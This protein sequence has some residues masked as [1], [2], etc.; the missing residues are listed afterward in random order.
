MI[1]NKLTLG[2]QDD[3]S[4]FT[5]TMVEMTWVQVKEAAENGDIV[6][7]PIGVIEE[8]GPHL[9][10]SPDVYMAYVFCKY[11][12]RNLERKGIK[13]IIAPPYY[14]GISK[15]VS[16]YPGTFSVRP[17]TMKAML[18]DILNSFNSWGFTN[19]FIINS[20]GDRIHKNSIE[21]SINEI[22][23]STSMHVYDMGKLDIQVEN[24][25]NFPLLR[26]ERFKP[27]YH[28][29][30]IETAA[31]F[32]FYPQKV[33]VEVATKMKPQNTF[34]P[35]G[36]CGDPASFLKETTVLEY[37]RADLEMDS[38]KIEAVLKRY[39]ELKNQ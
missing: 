21:Q 34:H 16:K 2:I 10:L 30:A 26:E 28:A 18:V 12:R 23:S 7:F 3:L 17:E 11:L 4:I 37:F 6:L 5:E 24:P 38:L 33:N 25:P 20:H 15:D 31:V 1:Q 13:S 39:K 29:G 19:V 14:W 32:A 27:D 22:Q 35:L 9:D 36:Y 8:H